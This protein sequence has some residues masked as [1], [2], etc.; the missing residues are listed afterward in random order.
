M[1]MLEPL[2]TFQLGGLFPAENIDQQSP[3]DEDSE[4]AL[5][6]KMWQEE[7]DC[8]SGPDHEISDDEDEEEV[9][10]TEKALMTMESRVSP[11]HSCSL[12]LR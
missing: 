2:V 5:V 12:H 1:K 9:E 4:A 6:S 7:E 11:N 10:E 8:L 3:D